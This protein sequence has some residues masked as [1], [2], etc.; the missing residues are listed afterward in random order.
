MYV[1]SDL[2]WIARDAGLEGRAGQI[3]GDFE[4][5]DRAGFARRVFFHYKKSG[6]GKV[7][8]PFFMGGLPMYLNQ[9]A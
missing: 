9:A 8:P 6:D 7:I 5:K 4:A 1:I 2:P 3:S